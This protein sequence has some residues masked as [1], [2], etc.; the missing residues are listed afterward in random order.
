M[1][2]K[3][4]IR[5]ETKPVCFKSKCKTCS[6]KYMCA[7]FISEGEPY[8]KWQDLMTGTTTTTTQSINY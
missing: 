4:S 7:N 2:D 5:N 8:I 6:Y 1:C 3:C